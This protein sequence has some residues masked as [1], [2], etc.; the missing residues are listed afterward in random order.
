[1]KY[2][3]A[4]ILFAPL[5]AMAQ[6][7]TPLTIGMGARL[8]AYQSE[9][10]TFRVYFQD[11]INGH[12]PYLQWRTNWVAGGVYTSVVNIVDASNGIAD[13]TFSGVNLATNGNF[14][15][16]AGLVDVPYVFDSGAFTILPSGLTSTNNLPP[17]TY[18]VDCSLYTWLNPPWS[19]TGGDVFKAQPNVF[20]ATNVA[21]ARWD[22][23]GGLFGHGT[24]LE[25]GAALGA[26]AIQPGVKLASATNADYA[27]TANVASGIVG[28]VTA[29]I[30]TNHGPVAV[31]AYQALSN[32]AHVTLQ[33]VLTYQST[34]TGLVN[35]VSLSGSNSTKILHVVQVGDGEPYAALFEAYKGGTAVGGIGHGSDGVG[36]Y[37]EGDTNANTIGGQFWNDDPAG[38]AV[39]VVGSIVRQTAVGVLPFYTIMDT[40]GYLYS[41][42]SGGNVVLTNEPQAIIAQ[43]GVAAISNL[44]CFANGPFAVWHSGAFSGSYATWELAAP[45]AS[46]G[47]VIYVGPGSYTI[48]PQGYT[49]AS[50]V[51]VAG[52]G[53]QL[54]TLA[55]GQCF[56]MSHCTNAFYGITFTNSSAKMFYVGDGVQLTID[57]CILDGTPAQPVILSNG[58]GSNDVTLIHCVV[59]RPISM[60]GTGRTNT[61]WSFNS[62]ITNI[63]NFAVTNDFIP[64]GA[65][66][67][68]QIANMATNAGGAGAGYYAWSNGVPTSIPVGGGETLW[69][70]ASNSIDSRIITNTLAIAGL[71][72]AY[73]TV[74]N[75]SYAASQNVVISSGVYQEYTNITNSTTLYF[76]TTNTLGAIASNF[77]IRCRFQP[78]T[79]AWTIATNSHVFLSSGFYVTNVWPGTLIYADRVS[80]TNALMLWSVNP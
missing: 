5:L 19:S 27:T 50:K 77:T 65:V 38:M 52:C 44:T 74:T 9:Q 14:R 10:I 2:A 1:M 76:D 35:E 32:A 43:G 20:T 58:A 25:V 16:E 26:T 55:A 54:T 48:T 56:V 69:P 47:D 39:D 60:S 64:Q 6:T 66:V 80:G 17:P 59:R 34:A 67:Q 63:C 23:N 29:D 33:Q 15:W 12:A 7:P 13:C 70:A 42:P 28:V 41:G 71:N 21:S 36:V 3:L 30:L 45:I 46:N 61:L 57:G 18:P 51:T 75:L 53:E 62:I 79:Q 11:D 72:S 49:L 31:T 24:N 37:G 73:Y 68:G 8:D 4:L 78:M 22:F 40:N